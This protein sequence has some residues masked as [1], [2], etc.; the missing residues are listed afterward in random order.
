KNGGAIAVFAAAERWN[1][2]S[3]AV[4]KKAGFKRIGFLSLWRFF[5]W[6]IFEFYRDIRFDIGQ[7]VLINK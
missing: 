7:I 1:F 2:A 4:F 5:G 3:L 6:R